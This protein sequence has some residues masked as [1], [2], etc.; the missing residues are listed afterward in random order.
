[1]ARYTTAA[2]C[3]FRHRR[4][5]AGALS[6]GAF[7]GQV[8]AGVGVPACLGSGDGEERAVELAVAAAGQS[9][10]GGVAA[11]GGD[12]LPR[13]R[14]RRT[15]RRRGSAARRGSRRGSWRRSAVRLRRWPAGAREG[16]GASCVGDHGLEV[17]GSR[18]SSAVGSGGSRPGPG[19]PAPGQPVRSFMARAWA[20]CSAA[21][22]GQ[23]TGDGPIAR[24]TGQS[25]T[26]AAG[27]APGSA[28]ATSWSR[29]STSS[30]RSA[31]RCAASIRRQ[32]RLLAD[33]DAGD[34]D[35][36]TLVVLA[37]APAARVVPARSGAS[38]TS[39]HLLPGREEQQGQRHGRT[40]WLPRRRPPA[41]P[42][43]AWIQV[44]IGPARRGPCRSSSLSI[45]RP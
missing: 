10:P 15:R 2:R 7:A 18:A 45:T 41:A 35:R 21:L 14:A 4:A 40:P 23:R 43:S 32:V 11:A 42:G 33:R 5:S 20:R 3:R 16:A 44:S 26:R 24:G 22:A 8:G 19:G 36:V 6:L 38:G 37:A 1:M 17:G 30:F 39:T 29:A 31:S 9:V 27:F 13:R 28:L 25:A 12:R 34:D